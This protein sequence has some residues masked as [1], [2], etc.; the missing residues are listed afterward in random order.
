[1]LGNGCYSVV[2]PHVEDDKVVKLTMMLNDGF[3]QYAE[4]IRDLDTADR[5]R[6]GPNLPVIHESF[7]HGG[8]LVTVMERLHPIK[9]RDGWRDE[10]PELYDALARAP[11]GYW[12]DLGYRNVMQRANGTLVVTDPWAGGDDDEVLDEDECQCSDCRLE[13]GES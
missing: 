1:V 4:W 12:N 3:A 13:R 2:V 9:D 6:F 5:E 8:V 10:I 7:E 11:D